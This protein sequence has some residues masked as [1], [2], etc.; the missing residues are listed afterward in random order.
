[1]R[2]IAELESRA[3]PKA[4]KASSPRVVS[5]KAAALVADLKGRVGVVK[6]AKVHGVGVGTV[7]KLKAKLAA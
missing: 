7:Q 5:H 3:K 6:L 4:K 2:A 1:L